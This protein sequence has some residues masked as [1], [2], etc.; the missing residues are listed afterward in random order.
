MVVLLDDT[1]LTNALHTTSSGNYKISNQVRFDGCGHTLG[2][3]ND[4]GLTGQV[5]RDFFVENVTVTNAYRTNVV[6]WYSPDGGTNGQE[7]YSA[8]RMILGMDFVFR[9]FREKWN[10]SSFEVRGGASLVMDEGSVIENGSTACGIVFIPAKYAPTN[11]S[12]KAKFIMNGGVIRNIAYASKSYST[13]KG[14]GAAVDMWGGVFEMNGGVI[15]NCTWDATAEAPDFTSAVYVGTN[16]AIVALNGG[17]ITNNT[18]G[19]YLAKDGSGQVARC[20]VKGN[21]VIAGNASGDYVLTSTTN[22]V[23]TG[24]FSGYIVVTCDDDDPDSQFG[25]WER[26]AGARNFFGGR[27][28]GHAWNGKLL[29]KAPGF[30]IFVR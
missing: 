9:D 3:T 18:V 23:Q 6:G 21:P 29:W 7:S 12:A 5:D 2:L 27:H 1:V 8:S 16:T 11:L 13:T 24:D 10:S 17:L 19:V 4:Q 14:L 20:E 26:G 15:S 28:S 22:L 25:L 30:C